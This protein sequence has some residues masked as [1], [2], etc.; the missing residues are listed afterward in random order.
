MMGMTEQGAIEQRKGPGL[1]ALILL[2]KHEQGKGKAA[3]IARLVNTT[4][5]LKIP[6]DIRSFP[7]TF[8]HPY[9]IKNA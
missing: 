9:S 2:K 8:N 5:K 6:F 7:L 1:T 3:Y 4:C